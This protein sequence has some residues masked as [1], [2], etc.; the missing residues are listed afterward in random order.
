MRRSMLTATKVVVPPNIQFG[1]AGA[2]DFGPSSTLNMPYPTGISAGHGLLVVRVMWNDN[3]TA[4]D[5]AGYANL[6]DG[7][8]GTGTA[9][10]AHT[11][12]IRMD[13]KVADGSESGTLAATAGGTA[14]SGSGQ[15]GVIIRYTNATGAWDV[16]GVGSSIG[17]ETTHGGN[18]ASGS[19]GNLDVVSGD[20]LVAGIAI[21]VVTALS[22]TSPA[23]TIGG[24][25]TGVGTKTI[26]YNTSGSSAGNDGNLEVVDAPY[27]G[28]NQTA[29]FAMSFSSGIAQCGPIGFVRLRQA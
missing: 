20:L 4:D 5:I 9:A 17:A 26:R 10:G 13:F 27:T 16:A 8:S 19:S 15:I 14:A 21:D 1:A 7:T 23:I 22:M 18:R 28:S 2:K 6:V 12:R 3:V 29:A 25:A 24:S 11:T